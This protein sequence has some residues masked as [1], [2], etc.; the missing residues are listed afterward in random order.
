M[1]TIQRILET[2]LPVLCKK[3]KEMVVL[4]EIRRRNNRVQSPLT[5][6]AQ[7]GCGSFRKVHDLDAFGRLVGVFQN[8]DLAILGVENHHGLV[9]VSGIW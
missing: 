1:G 4:N 7:L 5:I 6:V 3:G 9:L 8:I 2:V